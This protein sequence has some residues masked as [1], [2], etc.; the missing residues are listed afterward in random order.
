MLGG[1]VLGLG[2]EGGRRGRAI[3]EGEDVGEDGGLVVAD[4][5]SGTW[6]E[7]GTS[8]VGIEGGEEGGKGRLELGEVAGFNERLEGVE[9]HGLEYLIAAY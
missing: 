9:E 3:G 2:V 8:V 7:Q 1:G 6:V 4:G 5:V